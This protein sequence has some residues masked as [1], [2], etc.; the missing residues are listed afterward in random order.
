MTAWNPTQSGTGTAA[1]VN[2]AT[3]V[4][5]AAGALIFSTNFLP[6]TYTMHIN[7][8]STFPACKVVVAFFFGNVG[9]GQPIASTITIGGVAMTQAV[10]DAKNGL[11]FYADV[12]AGT[13][14]L[15]SLTW[16]SGSNPA[17]I[18]G[19]SA[20]YLIGAAAGG[21][22]SSAFASYPVF[23]ATST[24]L[25][26]PSNGAQTAFVYN[27]LSNTIQWNWT[28]AA[29]SFDIQGGSGQNLT[30]GGASTTAAGSVTITAT[31]VGTAGD[32]YYGMVS[33]A[34]AGAT[35]GGATAVVTL[36]ATVA[37]DGTTTAALIGEDTST[38]THGITQ[39]IAASAGLTY[40]AS[41]FAKAQQRSRMLLQMDD[42]AGSG[43][44][45]FVVFDLAGNQIG[46]PGA[47]FGSGYVFTSASIQDV[48]NGWRRCVLTGQ[49]GSGSPVYVTMRGDANSG[50]QPQNYN[51]LGGGSTYGFYAWGAQLEQAASAGPYVPTTSAPVTQTGE[52]TGT[53][54]LTV[55]ATNAAGTGTGTATINAAIPAVPVITAQ[56][57]NFT[58]PQNANFVVGTLSATN[59]PSSWAITGGDTGNLF[60]ISSTGVISLR[61]N[62]TTT[63]SESLTVTATNSA[64]TSNPATIP[65]SWAAAATSAF[66]EVV[67]GG[68]G[69]FSGIQ[70]L[71]GGIMMI[72]ND[73]GTAYYRT[74]SPGAGSDTWKMM[75]TTNNIPLPGTAWGWSAGETGGGWVLAGTNGLSGDIYDCQIAPTTAANGYGSQTVYALWLGYVIVSFNS[76]QTWTVCSN[77]PTANYSGDANGNG[78]SRF[79]QK[80]IRIDPANANR[81]I[82]A[83]P[84][85]GFYITSNG[86]SGASS[87]WTA[88]SSVPTPSHRNACGCIDYD[89][90]S[91]LSGGFTSRICVCTE[92]GVYI[93]T[94]AGS[95]F[96]LSPGCPTQVADSG[97]NNSGMANAMWHAVGGSTR[98][99]V[100]TCYNANQG[101]KLFMLSGTT[102][103]DVT[104]TSQGVQGCSGFDFD[105][106]DATHIAVCNGSGGGGFNQGIWNGSGFTWYGHYGYAG[107]SVSTGGDAP[108][109]VDIGFAGLGAYSSCA[110]DTSTSGASGAGRLWIMGGYTPL[111][112]DFPSKTAADGSWVQVTPIA[113]GTE[114]TDGSMARSI[115]S[116][117]YPYPLLFVD[118]LQVFQI[119]NPDLP[120]PQGS[121]SPRSRST[122][123]S[124]WGSDVSES[125]PGLVTILAD[126]YY[127]NAGTASG[128]STNGGTT[129]TLFPTAP[130]PSGGGGPGGNGGT[131]GGIITCT[132]VNHHV[133]VSNAAGVTPIYTANAG[134]SWQA[135]SGLPAGQ[136][137]GFFRRNVNFCNDAGGNMY[138]Y[139]NPGGVYRSTNGGANFSNMSTRTDICSNMGAMNLRSVP[140]RTGY[141]FITTGY[142]YPT[143]ASVLFPSSGTANAFW[144]S[145]D[146]GAT[147]TQV[148]NVQDVWCFGFG[149][150]YPGFTTPTLWVYAFVGP[151]GVTKKWGIWRSNDLGVSGN[152]WTRACYWDGG[153]NIPPDCLSGD[154]N[155]Y[156]KCYIGYSGMGFRYGKNIT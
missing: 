99:F 155:N 65:I 149:Q 15:L 148:P 29:F 58:E 123:A 115:N 90:T 87:T 147:W 124:A 141:L 82:V 41:V 138:A 2:V 140:G 130:W 16:P 63:G 86:L 112:V 83:T 89:T 7:N 18:N 108:W 69:Y 106:N 4:N 121:P 13:G 156:Q 139:F 59:T 36:N 96:T 20:W 74:T 95:S 62:V 104:P 60:Q 131:Y 152:N 53:Y 27:N 66:G 73:S 100:S 5:G 119:T 37:P 3:N 128:Y 117:S 71:P 30:L 137:S 143:N 98:L 54:A 19:V 72:H 6:G 113:R 107:A 88:I 153:H 80:R 17:G 26:T 42:G 67:I 52:P 25:T 136:W 111:W 101:E 64:G 38:N 28:G 125:V 94:N 32:Y 61:V 75:L 134:S 33:A 116:S 144:Y 57:F 118:D 85:N 151:G 49:A 14:D 10:S 135:C 122:N 76:G 126:G 79:A 142:S 127:V 40:T 45:V 46:V 132:D 56:S 110:F 97:G 77:F 81:V 11:I 24:T 50:T 105:P 35:T 145:T 154:M 39:H 109:M 23:E 103:S 8:N 150:P 1:S 68:G 9:G 21:P 91:A 22:T 34:W 133:A 44:G 129:W 146:G 93:S 78:Q 70:M 114:S 55:T 31:P 102:W 92:N 43:N 48:G 84:A 120:P 47:A 51:Y 12:V